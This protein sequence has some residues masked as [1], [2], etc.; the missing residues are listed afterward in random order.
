[1]SEENLIRGSSRTGKTLGSH[2]RR[3]CEVCTGLYNEDELRDTKGNVPGGCKRTCQDCELKLYIAD[4][5]Q[6]LK[7]SRMTNEELAAGNWTSPS[8]LPRLIISCGVLIQEKAA[9]AACCQSL[10]TIVIDAIMHGMPITQEVAD[11]RNEACRLLRSEN[12]QE[13]GTRPG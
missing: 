6:L 11:A 13:E 8:I 1:M 7:A 4:R 12:G 5:D 2:L 10:L 3:Q 9:L